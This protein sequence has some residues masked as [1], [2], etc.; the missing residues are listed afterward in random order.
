MS[1]ANHRRKIYRAINALDEVLAVKKINKQP[2]EK[3]KV[4]W[5]TGKKPKIYQEMKRS[6][7]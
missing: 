5:K 4:D 7:K 2:K 3:N 1:I 6:Q